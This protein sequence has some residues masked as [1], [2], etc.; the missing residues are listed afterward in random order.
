MADVYYQDDLVTLI[1]GDARDVIPTLDL[2]GKVD[3]L[4]TDPPYGMQY[5]GRGA[6]RHANIRGDGARQGMRLVRQVMA[7][8]EPCFAP[9]AHAYL[10]CHWESWP[11]FYDAASSYIA[12]KNALVWHKDRGGVGDTECEYARDFEVILYGIRGRRAL[13]GR[14][15]G[16]VLKG[17]Y[18]DPPKRRIHPTQKPV[19]LLKYLITKSCPEGGLVIDPFA[20]AASTLVAARL[21]GRR[22]IGIELDERWCEPAA[23]RLRAIASGES[24]EPAA[25]TQ[26]VQL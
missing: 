8:L 24:N 17:F 22:A 2:R 7:E 12:I 21:L 20:G 25:L 11:D 15:D 9:E 3:L 26:E 23:Q 5:E 10:T 13:H 16:A 6:A 1:R 14:R 19:A 4:L 18:P